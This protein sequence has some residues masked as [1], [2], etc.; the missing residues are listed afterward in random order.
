MRTRIRAAMVGSALAIGLSAVAAA[1]P[2]KPKK[3]PPQV[4]VGE[5]VRYSQDQDDG[6]ISF[7]L[8]STCQA[9]LECSISWVLRCDGDGADQ[10]RQGA[11]TFFLGTGQSDGAR[12][13]ADECGDKGWSIGK[14]RWSCRSP[15]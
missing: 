9:D 14:V 11:R 15:E 12:G 8:K 1:Q 5:C 6:G 13:S 4:N 2:K 3:E 10:K 7:V